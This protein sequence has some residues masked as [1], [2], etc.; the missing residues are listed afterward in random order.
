MLQCD[1]SN[2]RELNI[3]KTEIVTRSSCELSS[4]NAIEVI[5]YEHC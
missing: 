2:K 4:V 1:K 5:S 3:I